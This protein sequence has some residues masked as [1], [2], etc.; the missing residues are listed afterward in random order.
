MENKL[1][2]ENRLI[3]APKLGPKRNYGS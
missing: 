1:E 3:M 2:I